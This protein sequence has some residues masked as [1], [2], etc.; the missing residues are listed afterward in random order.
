MTVC[1]IYRLY[2]PSTY[3]AFNSPSGLIYRLSAQKYNMT[4][5]TSDTI[6][7]MGTAHQT[8]TRPNALDKRNAAGNSTN[9]WRTNDMKRLSM[10]LPMA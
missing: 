3:S 6:S 10:P 8:P 1:L 9:N 5:S 7:A 2:F 4:H